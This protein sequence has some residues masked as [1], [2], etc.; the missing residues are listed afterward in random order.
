MTNPQA[1]VGRTDEMHH[2]TGCLPRPDRPVG[3][4]AF[5]IGDAGTGKSRLVTELGRR[6]RA[7]GLTVLTGRSS[8]NARLTHCRP[9]AEALSALS[10]SRGMPADPEL[11]PLRPVLGQ[12]VPEWTRYAEVGPVHSPLVLAE[13]VLRLLRVVGRHHGCLLVVEDLHHADDETLTVTEYLLDNLTDQ[14]TALVGTARADAGAAI[15]LADTARLRRTARLVRLDP[16]D[17]ESVTLLAARRLGVDPDRVPPA[18]LDRLCAHGDGNPFVVEELL[19]AMVCDGVLVRHGDGWRVDAE[20]GRLLPPTV[21]CSIEQR[22]RHLPTDV[23]RTLR[24]AA[25]IGAVFPA[26]VLR[27]TLGVTE[28]ALH[29]LLDQAVDHRFV[30]ADDTTP[31]RYRFRE[32]LAPDALLA[33][34]TVAERQ[35]LAGRLADGVQDALPDPA[36]PWLPHPATL[37]HAAGD[38][39]TAAD[40]H[41]EAGRVAVARGLADLGVDQL[42]RAWEST[43]DQPAVDRAE[44]LDPLLGALV[45]AGEPQRAT[46]LADALDDLAEAVP[47]TRLAR[48][49]MHLARVD[50]LAGQHHDGLSRIRRARRDLQTATDRGGADSGH[51]APDPAATRAALD[52]VEANLLLHLP[53]E[54][55]GRV[56]ELADRAGRTGHPEQTCAALEVRAALSARSDVEQTRSHLQELHAEAERHDL[57]G[58]RLRSSALLATEDAWRRGCADRLPTVRAQAARLGQYPITADLDAT[59][60][61]VAVLN[62]EYERAATLVDQLRRDAEHR[63]LPGVVRQAALV[64]AICA[65]HQGHHRQMAEH[66]TLFH[67]GGTPPRQVATALG[68]AEVCCALLEEDR[69]HAVELLASARAAEAAHPDAYDLSGTHGLALLLAAVDGRTDTGYRDPAAASR[70][71]LRWNR[72]FGLAA[73]AVVA[74]RAGRVDE[75]IA[76]LQQADQTAAPFPLARHLILRLA[77]EAALADGW[78]PAADWVRTA[79]EFFRGRQAPAPAA[80][81]RALLRRAGHPVNQQR[82]GCERIPRPL[83]LAGVTA[84][85]FEVLVLLTGRLRNA[86]IGRRLFI[87]DRTVEKHVT[88]LL[89]KVGKSTRRELAAFAAT[90]GLATEG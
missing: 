47:P 11:E 74:G 65:A 72:Q 68:L 33:G 86:E 40:L 12:L 44:V 79:E 89:V 7:G 76:A 19:T 78:G 3:R 57:P 80:A 49:R 61:L 9:Y 53:D 27:A 59:T 39:A 75:A 13:A 55:P 8:P 24:A 25:L 66:L 18:V 82:R 20:P 63:G 62:G 81:C 2:L 43:S 69:P 85:E 1:L 6:A 64:A 87:S 22:L 70:A 83:R 34:L 17:P 67:D 46:A 51:P 14:P 35:D 30:R 48:L 29:D 52:L 58:W 36:T 88:N 26:D 4:S 41:A 37:R 31:G 15:D 54:P 16:L 71:D 56:A 28:N 10:R 77:G 38:L 32:A 60:A 45:D 23:H 5:L 50:G 21:V 90:A 42:T 73:G 84:R